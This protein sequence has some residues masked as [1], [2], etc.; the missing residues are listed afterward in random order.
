MSNSSRGA[1]LALFERLPPEV[2]IQIMSH[3]VDLKSLSHLLLASRL[4]KD[5]FKVNETVLAKELART[6]IG[7]GQFKLAMIAAASKSV[8]PLDKPAVERFLDTYISHAEWPLQRYRIALVARAIHMNEDMWKITKGIRGRGFEE[9]GLGSPTFTHAEQR[10]LHI[11]EMTSNLFLPPCDTTPTAYSG[12]WPS[13]NRRLWSYIP[14]WDVARIDYLLYYGFFE[15][16]R[17]PFLDLHSASFCLKCP[18][19]KFAHRGLCTAVVLLSGLD[20]WTGRSDKRYKVAHRFI[21]S[22]IICPGD[23]SHHVNLGFLEDLSLFAQSAMHPLPASSPFYEDETGI[24]ALCYMFPRPTYR[25]IKHSNLIR[26]FS[27]SPYESLRD[28]WALG[29]IDKARVPSMFEYN[30]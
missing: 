21:N 26:I 6:I 8:N 7:P 28:K 12:L 20:A 23:E 16:I 2:K 1:A 17:F 15:S 19:F 30:A 4:Y 13:L 25:F 29:Y 3:L 9:N 27:M 14:T 24:E 11:C 10:R 22:L 5:T 18:N